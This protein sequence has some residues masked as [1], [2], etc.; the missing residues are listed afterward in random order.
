VAGQQEHWGVSQRGGKKRNRARN[1]AT[2]KK[3]NGAETKTLSNC[4]AMPGVSN[5]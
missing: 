1:A 3:K 4:T 5:K 2:I